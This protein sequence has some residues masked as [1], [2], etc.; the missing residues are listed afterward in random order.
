MMTPICP[1]LL[2]MIND[3]VLLR[4]RARAT[5]DLSDI[6]I[7]IIERSYYVGYAVTAL[8]AR[9]PAKQPVGDAT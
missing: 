6:F 9:L 2:S 4:F 1:R 5:D 8:S 7:I 3:F